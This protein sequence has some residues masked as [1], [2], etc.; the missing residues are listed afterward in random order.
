MDYELDIGLYEYAT[1]GCA[2][3]HPGGGAME[4]DR[5]GNRYDD[6]SAAGN[7]PAY[8]NGDYYYYNTASGGAELSPWIVSGVLE[9][10]CLICH[11]EGYSTDDRATQI[12]SKNLRAAPAAGAGFG[13]VVDNDTVKYD[14]ALATLGIQLNTGMGYAHN[15]NQCHAMDDNGFF[16]SMTKIKSP[17]SDIRKR[18]FVWGE[19]GALQNATSDYR[20]YHDHEGMTCLDCHSAGLDHQI[21]KGNA[22]SSTV[23]DDL[24]FTVISCAECHVDDVNDGDKTGI[25]PAGTHA[26]YGFGNLYAFHKPSIFFADPP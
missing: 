13:T 1:S 5:N 24:D 10:D 7:I 8:L 26:S 23:R 17:K 14:P 20:D 18:G 22:R 3:C 16:T 4:Y 21:T 11:M 15:C 2:V 19:G 9:I 6:F 12:A 25:D